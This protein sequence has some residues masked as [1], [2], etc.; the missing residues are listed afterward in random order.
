MLFK[1]SFPVITCFNN[2]KGD[3]CSAYPELFFEWWKSFTRGKETG[4][5][6]SLIIVSSLVMQ[7]WIFWSSSSNFRPHHEAL[8][9]AGCMHLFLSFTAILSSKSL[10]SFFSLYLLSHLHLI[11]VTM[12]FFVSAICPTW[13]PPCLFTSTAWRSMDV[14]LLLGYAKCYT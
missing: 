13:R 4:F 1:A 14:S 3:G 2:K 5:M 11:K 6:D 9:P 10:F 12:Q 7:S 8:E